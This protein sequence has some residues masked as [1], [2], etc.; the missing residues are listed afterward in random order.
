MRSTCS[1]VEASS[2]ALPRGWRR[3]VASVAWLPGS[4]R[5]STPVRSAVAASPRRCRRE[6]PRPARPRGAPARRPRAARPGRR[7][8]H[9]VRSC[10]DRSS[11]SPR[12]S[13]ASAIP[14][15]PRARER[16]DPRAAA[17]VPR[18]GAEPLHQGDVDLLA[19][20]EVVV[21]QPARDP[22]GARDVLDQHLLVPAL[23]EQRVGGVEDLVAPLCGGEALVPPACSPGHHT[24][25]AIR[26]QLV[27]ILPTTLKPPR[28]PPRTDSSRHRRRTTTCAR[29]SSASPPLPQSPARSP[30]PRRPSLTP[31]T[32]PTPSSRRR[33]TT[34][35]RSA[36][37]PRRSSRTASS[38]PEVHRP[39]RR[40]NQTADRS[41]QSGRARPLT[42]RTT[43]VKLSC[44]SVDMLP[45]NLDK[46]TVNDTF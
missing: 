17:A 28:V 38:S 6:R 46:I 35:A 19:A 20:A 24:E 5:S 10:R 37:S 44:T 21:H 34:P 30:S 11:G 2:S 13:P 32:A 40:Q 45:K 16:C 33:T 8:P 25:L 3:R 9:P 18:G 36:S 1:S 26:Q 29:S 12:S 4:V 27:S 15:P 43:A 23:G 14:S 22:S 7:C 39:R 31:P 41:E 42:I